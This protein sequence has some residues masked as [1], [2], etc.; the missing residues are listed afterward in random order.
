MQLLGLSAS[1]MQAAMDTLL[2]GYSRV[3]SGT[4]RHMGET[5]VQC[6][7]ARFEPDE[8]RHWYDRPGEINTQTAPPAPGGPERLVE[9]LRRVIPPGANQGRVTRQ[10]VTGPSCPANS[11]ERFY[12]PSP[13]P[14]GNCT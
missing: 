13:I 3:A 6:M 1:P 11:L 12:T 14:A 7:Y 8:I 10:P 5:F 2:S 4:I 9:D